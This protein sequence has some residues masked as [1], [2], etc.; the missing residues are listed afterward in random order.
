MGNSDEYGN[1]QLILI[2]ISALQ[3][4]TPLENKIVSDVRSETILKK[5]K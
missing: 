2:Q 1:G 3:L 4:R 5:V